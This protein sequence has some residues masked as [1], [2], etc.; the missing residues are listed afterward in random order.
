MAKGILVRGVYLCD[1][2]YLL[3]IKSANSDKQF[4]PEA[5]FN[6]EDDIAI[7]A[8]PRVAHETL[9]VSLWVPMLKGLIAATVQATIAISLQLPPEGAI[10]YPTHAVRQWCIKPAA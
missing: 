2:C 3:D 9:L 8:E 5:A 6:D 10:C 7:C 1:R 4:W